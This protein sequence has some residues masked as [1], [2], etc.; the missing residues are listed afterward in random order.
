VLENE[1][2]RSPVDEPFARMLA[3]YSQGGRHALMG[4]CDAIESSEE[5]G[6]APALALVEAVCY[7]DAAERGLRSATWVM[8]AQRIGETWPA[9]W[10]EVLAVAR[11][12]MPLDAMKYERFEQLA[13]LSHDARLTAD[14]SDREGMHFQFCRE[15]LETI[16]GA[17]TGRRPARRDMLHVISPWQSCLVAGIRHCEGR[18]RELGLDALPDDDGA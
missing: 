7:D 17:T 10:A 15:S 3:I 1:L 8:A 2:R 12:A 11:E 5:P 9:S 14:A 6:E 4:L 13:M 18:L 16:I